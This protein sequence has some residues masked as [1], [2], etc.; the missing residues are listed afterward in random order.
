MNM[1]KRQILIAAAA[2]LAVAAFAQNKTLIISESG[3]P[4]T[5]QCWFAYGV[6]ND[7]DATDITKGWN[8]GRRIV[9]AAYTSEGWLVIMA[10]NTGYSRQS[11]IL[12]EEWPEQWIA[13]K[14]RENFAITALS[15]SGREWLVVM[16]QGSGITRQTVWRNSWQ[17]LAPWITEQKGN[18]YFITDLAYD[19]EAWTVVMSQNSKFASQGYFWSDTTDDASMRVQ[20]DVWGRG[21]N[22]HQV[23]YG[24]GKYMVVFGNYRV[25]DDRFQNL[26]VNPVDPRGYIREQWDSKKICV[27]YVGGGIPE[28][29]KKSKWK[30][31]GK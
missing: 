18:G 12:S 1:L 3:L 20:H 23:E 17:E 29:P 24:E 6:G 13:D 9:T 19:G 10:K 26:Q 8:E 28:S 27:A 11:F 5:E 15:R 31:F 2:F 4:Y 21:F 30:L 14:T 16:S 7:L 25:G 22:L